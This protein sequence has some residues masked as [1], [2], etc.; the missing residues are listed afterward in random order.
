[1]WISLCF[2]EE[3]DSFYIVRRE[4]GREE[5][6]RGFLAAEWGRWLGVTMKLR[7]VERF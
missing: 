3:T 1:M 2:P 5:E 4:R 7:F 6:V